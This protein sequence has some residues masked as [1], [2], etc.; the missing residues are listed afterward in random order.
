MQRIK[1]AG[2]I[3]KWD[4]WSLYASKVYYNISANVARG[5]SQ[6]DN[7]NMDQLRVVLILGILLQAFGICILFCEWIST[8]DCKFF[9]TSRVRKQVFQFRPVISK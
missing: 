9:Q 1:E 6:P 8:Y 4:N 7:I 5:H 2:L 3:E